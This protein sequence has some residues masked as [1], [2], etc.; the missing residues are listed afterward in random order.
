MT[1]E[2]EE[3]KK[4]SSGKRQP[5][6]DDFPPAKSFADDFDEMDLIEA[7]IREAMAMEKDLVSH[8]RQMGATEACV[9]IGDLN[10]DPAIS[11][12]SLLLTADEASEIIRRLS[13]RW[14]GQ[15]CN[16]AWDV[17]NDIEAAAPNSSAPNSPAPN[18]PAPSGTKKH[19]DELKP[20]EPSPPPPKRH[21]RLGG[22]P[23]KRFS[24]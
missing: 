12:Y 7:R 6:V 23:P 21:R 9:V 4:K 10:E 1:S 13:P 3:M 15:S 5:P 17:L 24:T 20:E 14:K 22:F 18:S 11:V 2:F 19:P 16:R 8:L